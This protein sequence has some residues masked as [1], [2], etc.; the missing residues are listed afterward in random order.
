M[1]R[2]MTLR[3]DTMQGSNHFE[4]NIFESYVNV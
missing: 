3:V 2:G 4:V 1:I